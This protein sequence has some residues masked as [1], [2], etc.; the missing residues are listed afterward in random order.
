MLEPLSER[1]LER[2]KNLSHHK[3]NIDKSKFLID[4][5]DFKGYLKDNDTSKI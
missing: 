2:K 3:K 5:E 1:I 4:E